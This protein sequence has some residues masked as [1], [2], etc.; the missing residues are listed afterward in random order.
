MP[1]RPGD[2]V[3][4]EQFKCEVCGSALVATSQKAMEDLV[5][6][7]SMKWGETTASMTCPKAPGHI[8]LRAIPGFVDQNRVY[9]VK[10]KPKL[11][12]TQATLLDAKTIRDEPFA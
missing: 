1:I 11:N 9:P 4:A 12:G 10:P 7:R 2:V 8:G 5:G 3:D 6:A